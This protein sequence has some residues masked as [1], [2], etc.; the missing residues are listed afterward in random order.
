MKDSGSM[1]LRS[2]SRPKRTEMMPVGRLAGTGSRFRPQ[3][4]RSR[5]ATARRHGHRLAAEV[6]RQPAREPL[7]ALR[8]ISVEGRFARRDPLDHAAKV[9]AAGQQQRH[10]FG[11][12]RQFPCSHQVEHAL[13][14]M[15]ERDYFVQAE[16]ACRSFDGVCRAEDGIHGLA[17]LLAILESQQ[18]VF[19][20]LQQFP[21]FGNERL[22]SCRRDSWL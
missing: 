16:Q 20:R 3:W 15:R 7:P 1:P 9:V 22:Q 17:V 4:R 19:H 2:T 14:A 10:Q 8:G 5:G 11:I 12:D 6:A 21:R 13:Q 18:S